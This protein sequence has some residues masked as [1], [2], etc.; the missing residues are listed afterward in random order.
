MSARGKLTRGDPLAGSSLRP[1]FC[2]IPDSACEVGFA[3]RHGRT[4]AILPLRPDQWIDQQNSAA[5]PKP[6][7]GNLSRKEVKAATVGNGAASLSALRR[8]SSPRRCLK[9]LTPAPITYGAG[10]PTYFADLFVLPTR[11][12][13]RHTSSKKCFASYGTIRRK[14]GLTILRELTRLTGAAT[15]QGLREVCQHDRESLEKYRRL[16]QA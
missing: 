11:G 7:L 1:L 12:S 13:I 16:L 4:C 5:Q 3:D 14:V 8:A 2:Y 10:F 9:V 6:K 15:S